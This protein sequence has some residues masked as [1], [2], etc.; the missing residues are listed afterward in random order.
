MSFRSASPETKYLQAYKRSTTA[1]GL[2]TKWME[3]GECRKRSNS[4]EARERLTKM[5]YNERSTTQTRA[6][7]KLCSECSV[8]EECWDYALKAPHDNGIW[9]GTTPRERFKIRRGQRTPD[10]YWSGAS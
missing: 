5:F 9:G 4:A 10:H 6:A 2:P 7:K 1:T 8:K 3:E